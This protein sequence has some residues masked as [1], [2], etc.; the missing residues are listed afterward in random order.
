MIHEIQQKLD[1][2][3]RKEIPDS[4]SVIFHFNGKKVLCRYDMINP[5]PTAFDFHMKNYAI[6]DAQG[7]VYLFTIGDRKYFLLREYIAAVLDVSYIYI[8]VKHFR[9]IEDMDKTQV[10]ALATAWHLSQWYDSTAFCGY[11][12]GATVISHKERAVKCSFCGKKVFPRINPA[13]IAGVTNGDK[14]LITRYAEK[15]GVPYD[16]LIA[17]FTEIGEI[18]EETV[19]RE[20]MEEVGLK[21]KNI[22]YYKSQPWGY[23]GCVLMGFFCDVDGDST[24]TMDKSELSS[25]EWVQR[26]EIKAQPDDLSLTNDMMM[27]FRNFP[28]Q[29]S[30]VLTLSDIIL[31]H[32]KKVYEELAK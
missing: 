11:C 21:V 10:F 30:E 28:A 8:D 31:E 20:V 5:F 24:I 4:N 32:N 22:R 16:A 3:F 17:G 19:Q 25:A 26:D 13:V 23:T 6:K 27:I 29:N 12:G 15:R 1:N 7:L 18:P 14:L 2:S 9:S